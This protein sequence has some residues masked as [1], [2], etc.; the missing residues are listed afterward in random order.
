MARHIIELELRDGNRLVPRGGRAKVKPGDTVIF[1]LPAGGS[2]GE[3][4]FVGNSPFAKR[5]VD[6]GTEVQVVRQ[7]QN[8]EATDVLPFTCRGKINGQDVTSRSGGEIEI[9]RP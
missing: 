1:K 7:H 4:T 9:I 6:Y 5:T 2:G 8:D 3:I